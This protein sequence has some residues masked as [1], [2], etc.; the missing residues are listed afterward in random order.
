[1][2]GVQI[3]TGTITKRARGTGGKPSWG[4]Y[5]L[6]G[7]DEAG[8]RIQLTK[9]GFETKGAAADALRDAIRDFEAKR[10]AA[11]V[12][13][14]PTLATFFDRWMSEHATRTCAP[15]TVE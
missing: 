12:R 10:D 2:A 11:P 15:K 14:I 4:Y 7:K 5:F 8:K 1:M 6:A 3:M 13:E 9:S